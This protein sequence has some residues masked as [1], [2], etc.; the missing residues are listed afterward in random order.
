MCS[1]TSFVVLAPVVSCLRN[2]RPGVKR[3]LYVAAVA[4]VLSFVLIY[5]AP[6]ILA[7]ASS[8]AISSEEAWQMNAVTLPVSLV[9]LV[10]LCVIASRRDAPEASHVPPSDAVSATRWK[11][12]APIAV[13]LLFFFTGLAV[14]G[15]SVLA[16][17]NVALLAGLA[18]ALAPATTDLRLEAT[19]KGTRHAGIIIFDLCGAGALGNVIATSQFPSQAYAGLSAVLPAIVIPFALAA[20]VQTAQGSRVTTAVVTSGIIGATAMGS[21]ILP[22]VLVLE[23]CA[24]CC[25]ISYVSD[26]FFWLLARVTGD[27]FTGVAKGYTLPLAAIGTCILIVAL[28]AQAL[29]GVASI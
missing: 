15:L 14:P 13:P 10:A 8:L 16:N 27:D 19:A 22:L 12:W 4:G 23:I 28:I 11:A 29:F 6:V 5:P 24:G 25:M 21:G 18:V 3:L 26:P 1:I 17:I 2:D 20:L 7:I 9:L